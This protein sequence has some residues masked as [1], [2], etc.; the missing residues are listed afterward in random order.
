MQTIRSYF[1]RWHIISIFL[2][3]VD[4]GSPDREVIWRPFNGNYRGEVERPAAL[5][6]LNMVADAVIHHWATVVTGKAAGLEG[7]GRAVQ[8]IYKFS[9][10]MTG[11]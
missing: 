5:T 7:F 9:T 3:E 8:N 1:N 2:G 11:S 4:N 6:I 10:W